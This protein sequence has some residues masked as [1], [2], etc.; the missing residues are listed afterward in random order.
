[1]KEYRNI[2]HSQGYSV[3]DAFALE[4][5]I[6]ASLMMMILEKAPDLS[7]ESLVK[8]ITAMKDGSYKGLKLNFNPQTRELVHMLWID[9]GAPEWIQQKLGVNE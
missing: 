4:G 5:F 2:L 1:M 6:A 8:T 7:N 9:T 3:E